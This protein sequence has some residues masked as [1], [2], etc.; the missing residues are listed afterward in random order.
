[1]RRARPAAG[2]A[3]AA[4]IVVAAVT[5]NVLWTA[6]AVIC[7]GLGFVIAWRAV[8][9]QHGEN[10]VQYL[11]ACPRSSGESPTGSGERISDLQERP[12]KNWTRSDDAVYFLVMIMARALAV[13]AVLGVLAGAAPASGKVGELYALRYGAK[14][15]LLVPYDPVRLV[16]SGSPIRMGQFGHAWSISPDRQRLVAAAGVRRKGEPTVVRFVELGSRRIE[17]TVTLPGE[18][19]RVTA[20]AW[21]RGR[22]LVVVSGSSATRVYAVDPERRVTVS[23]IEFPGTVVL[24]ERAQSALVLLLATPNQIGP[25]TIAV[26]DQSPRVQ[27]VVLKRIAVGTA[28]TGDGAERRMTIRRPA[29]TLGPSGRRAFVIGAGEYPAAIDL[30]TLSVRYAPVRLTAASTKRVEGSMRIAETLPD[31]RIIVGASVYG[32]IGAEDTAGLWIIDPKDWSR[33]V[34]TTNWTWFRVAGGLIFARGETGVGLR[35]IQPSGSSRELFRT[36]SVAR[37]TV[38]GPRAFVTFFGTN[39]KAAVVELGTGRVVR[40]PVPAYPLVGAGQPITG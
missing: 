33:R 11:G 9:A 2:L 15:N 28:T 34:L 39:I 31:G 3:A 17:G 25:A 24:G 35:I 1:M 26:V 40:H 5:S 20:T 16:P 14:M 29:L 38:V 32:A 21:I 13:A 6:I 18:F 22:V 30:R 23:Q 27:T 10:M 4:A 7:A 37:V 19:S 12:S 36:G 8:G